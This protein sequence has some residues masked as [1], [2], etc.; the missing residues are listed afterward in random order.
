[1]TARRWYYPGAGLLIFAAFVAAVV[2]RQPFPPKTVVMTT[3]APGSAHEAFA[4]QYQRILARSGVELRLMPSTGAVENLKRLNDPRSAVSVGFAQGGLTDDDQS[5]ELMSLGTLFYEPLW[6]FYRSAK[7]HTQLNTLNGGKLAIGP[8]GSATRALALQLLAL[9]GIG[10]NVMQLLPLTAAESVV[11]LEKGEID[12]AMM[13]SSW[14]TEAVRRLLASSAI[15]L[16][17]F[18][19]A[20][21]YVALYP[22]LSKVIVPAGVGNLATNRPRVNTYL[23][24]AKASLIVRKDLHPAIQ[25]L[26]LDAAVEIHSRAGI[27]NTAGQFPAAE[28]VDLPLSQ[29]ALQFYKSGPPLLIRSMPFWLAVLLR[30][31]LVLLIPVV[32]VAYP[33]LRIA[34]GVYGWFIRRRIFDLYGE[35]KLIEVEL[36]AD[37]GAA[38]KDLKVQLDRLEERANHLHIPVGFA[39]VLYSLR[40]HIN[41][42]RDRLQELSADD[43]PR[44]SR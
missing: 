32:G 11:P 37:G 42:V 44:P 9:N 23:L 8:E 26:L 40:I 5:P 3:G 1:M 27:F 30:S 29:D 4:R 22:F 10:P 17:T 25:N 43:A 14:D 20:D 28:L 15:E 41:L 38:A 39:D 18:P 2:W 7:F 35:L 31:W 36:E 24:A 13:M 16:A 6:F 33:L 12:A 21:A 19:R 34:P